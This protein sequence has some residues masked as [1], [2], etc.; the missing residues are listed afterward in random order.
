MSFEK[1]LSDLAVSNFLMNSY[2]DEEELLEKVLVA[3]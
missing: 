3:S 2:S 1:L